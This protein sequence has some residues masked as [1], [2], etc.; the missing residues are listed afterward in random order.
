ML[1]KSC[2]MPPV[3][4]PIASIFCI[5]RTCASAASRLSASSVRRRLASASASRAASAS[6]SRR[7]LLREWRAAAAA[8]TSR[9]LTPSAIAAQRACWLAFAVAA[10]EQPVLL[11]LHLLHDVAEAGPSPPCRAGNFRAGSERRANNSD[12]RRAGSASAPT[13]QRAQPIA[14]A[15]SGAGLS[16][17][18][19]AQPG[20]VAAAGRASASSIGLKEVA[21]TGQQ[22]AAAA[23]F[24]FLKAGD[25][26][27]ASSLSTLERMA[28]PVERVL[29]ADRE[30]DRA[31]D[32]R[33]QQQ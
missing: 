30:P 4:W 1:L 22:E 26:S 7:R 10:G 21:A 17:T 31:R 25:R 16:V 11:R 23:R 32:R 2:A 24:G 8:M 28:D 27:A 12:R 15:R 6:A 9:A 20:E 5:C 13:R 29:L 33:D 14:P 18:S 19:R 3:S